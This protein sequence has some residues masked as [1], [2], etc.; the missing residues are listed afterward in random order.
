VAEGVLENPA[1]ARAIFSVSDTGVL[2]YGALGSLNNPSRLFWLDRTGKKVG[3]VGDPALHSAP[4]LSPDGKKLAVAIGDPSRATTDIW[5][6]DL[7]S[8]RRTRLTF[9]PSFN[10]QPV[11]SPDGSQ[12]VFFTTRGNGFPELYRK[13]SN[14]VGAE[15]PLLESHTQER[16]DDW[17]PDGKFIIFEPN[18]TLNSLWLVPLSG[19]RKPAV[20]LAGESGTYPTEARFSPNGKWLAYV[21]YGSGNRE[22]YITPFPGKTGKWQVSVAGGRYPRWR[23]DGK[24]LFFLTKNDTILTAVDVDLSGSAPRHSTFSKNRHGRFQESNLFQELFEEIVARCVEAGLVRG[25]HMSVDGSFIQANADRDSCWR[26]RSDT[27]S[28]GTPALFL[29]EDRDRINAHDDRRN[30]HEPMMRHEVPRGRHQG[31]AC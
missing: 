10:S 27:A 14:G 9:D 15:E 3:T 19:N 25:K 6:Y 2:A 22:I 16:P 17:S 26:S 31:R 4:R 29:Y 28:E 8:G 24:E 21:L 30:E 23:A 5:I 18:A 20:F 7:G 12:I 11:W 1:Y 13:A